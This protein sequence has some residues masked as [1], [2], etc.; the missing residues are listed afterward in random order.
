[1]DVSDGNVSVAVLAGAIIVVVNE[2]LVSVK[3]PFSIL[4]LRDIVAQR[5][6]LFANI[7]NIGCMFSRHLACVH[8]AWI[9]V[10]IHVRRIT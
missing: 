1:V 6:Q 10:R 3:M 4:T 8:T 5:I 7:K 2:P 9:L